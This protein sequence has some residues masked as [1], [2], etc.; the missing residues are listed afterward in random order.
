MQ[1]ISVPPCIT[2]LSYLYTPARTASP[3]WCAPASP[4]EAAARSRS[5]RGCRGGRGRAGTGPAPRA[6][7]PPGAGG[8]IDI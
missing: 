4:A 5:A 7:P 3:R 8:Y 1:D 6:R 2:L